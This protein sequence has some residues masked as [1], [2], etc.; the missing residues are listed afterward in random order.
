AW[1][2]APLV[3]CHPR[4]TAPDRRAPSIKGS[5]FFG[6]FSG[7][8]LSQISVEYSWDH[9]PNM[10]FRSRLAMEERNLAV[11]LILGPKVAGATF[12]IW[13]WE[14]DAL[15]AKGGK[16]RYDELFLTILLGF[17]SNENTKN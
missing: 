5:R 4:Y 12:D 14:S 13:P 1:H 8:M 7:L 15:R 3:S 2:I 11:P 10:R 6:T 9:A 16:K 17:K